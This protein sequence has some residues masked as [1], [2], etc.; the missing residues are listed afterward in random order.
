MELALLLKWAS[1]FPYRGR[2]ILGSSSELI[3]KGFGRPAIRIEVLVPRLWFVAMNIVN[4][5]F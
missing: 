4:R 3:N 5:R 2:S 1:P